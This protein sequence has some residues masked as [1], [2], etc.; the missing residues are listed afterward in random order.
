MKW[1]TITAD[2]SYWSFAN[3]NATSN[4]L[5]W[6]SQVPT[7]WG[8]SG[9]TWEN[10]YYSAYWKHSF[11]TLDQPPL[12]SISTGWIT[13]S[14]CDDCNL[15][16]QLDRTALCSGNSGFGLQ[17][18]LQF[19]PLTPPVCRRASG[20][21]VWTQLCLQISAPSCLNETLPVHSAD[22]PF[23][24]LYPF[25]FFE[26]LL[27]QTVIVVILPSAALSILSLLWSF[28][29]CRPS[30]LW[31]VILFQ[32]WLLSTHNFTFL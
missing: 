1:K 8:D 24:W 11:H 16:S 9:R 7:N 14:R 31:K 6:K 15:P 26:G 12:A 5:K 20:S 19:F 29:R 18:A 10:H 30:A 28:S 21:F 13:F 17:S 32:N 27:K 25:L 4:Q 22:A 23:T 3:K 2:D